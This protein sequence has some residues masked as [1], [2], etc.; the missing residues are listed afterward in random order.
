M[1][2]PFAVRTV[3]R[4]YPA[5][6]RDRYGDEIADLLATS[7]RPGHDLADAAWCALTERGSVMH[8]SINRAVVLR[9][10][11]LVCV[12]LAFAPVLLAFASVAAVALNAF[13]T[14]GQRVV[15]IVLAAAV[16]P[17]SLLAWW[18]GRRTTAATAAAPA[19][20]VALGV[21]VAALASVPILGEALGEQWPAA[22]LAAAC[23]AL[24]L[25][26][27]ITLAGRLRRSGRS[28]AAVTTS[29]LG[30]LV[31]LDT[32]GM[33]QMTSAVNAE[34]APRAAAPLWYLEAVSGLDLGSAAGLP[35][36]AFEMLKGSPAVLTVST[37]FALVLAARRRTGVAAADPVVVDAG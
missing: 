34:A 6:I 17:V 10:I 35:D 27:T 22:P 19:I 1:S 4:L 29:V 13:P 3:L 20:P 2:R 5:A 18:L 12:P 37:V 25:T 21:G 14:V 32:A 33:A 31:A 30:G 36:G 7:S 23:W 9:T 15:Q 26:A 8:G 11:K 28:R 24:I 16:L